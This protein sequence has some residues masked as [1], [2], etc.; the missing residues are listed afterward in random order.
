MYYV[1]IKGENKIIFGK[2]VRIFGDLKAPSKITMEFVA[3]IEP[4]VELVEFDNV[5]V[6]YE[7]DITVN[8]EE[9][10]NDIDAELKQKQKNVEVEKDEE[11]DGNKCKIV[12]TS[13][14][15]CFCC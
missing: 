15:S 12:D 7:T 1:E 4:T 8:D 3:E 11:T 2:D 9:I 13:F 6:K 10:Q 5:N 14:S